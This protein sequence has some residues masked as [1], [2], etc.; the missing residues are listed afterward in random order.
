VVAQSRMRDV[1]DLLSILDLVSKQCNKESNH[2]TGFF[3]EIEAGEEDKD[4][5]KHHEYNWNEELANMS[6]R[7]S[8]KPNFKCH[9]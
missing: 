2:S 5:Y 7:S 9:I 6:E 4:M 1:R 3:N 8:Y